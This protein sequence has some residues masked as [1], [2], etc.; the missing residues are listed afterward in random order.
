MIPT[1]VFAALASNDSMRVLVFAAIFGIG[2]VFREKRS[3]QSVFGA[4]SH[5]QEV[6]VLIFEWFSA[7]MP[8][9]I[10][11]LIAPQVALLG[12]EAY[13]VLALFFYAF[14]TVSALVLLGAL[15]VVS[16][17]VPVAN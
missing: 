14:P 13:A 16:A 5:I 15:L 1:T 7:F 3:G 6:C 4:L 2:M 12:T 9:G 10:I 11:V 17:V 8:A